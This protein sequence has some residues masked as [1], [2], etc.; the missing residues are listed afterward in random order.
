[1]KKL[2]IASVMFVIMFSA[3]LQAQVVK[4]DSVLFTNGASL[5]TSLNT[6]GYQITAIKIPDALAGTSITFQVND[7]LDATY[8]NLIKADGTEVKITVPASGTLPNR[9]L[10]VT[11]AENLAFNYL[12]KL[13]TGTYAAPTTQSAAIWVYVELTKMIG[14]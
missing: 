2:M 14:E 12:A 3:M 1:M 4:I 9:K 5:S 6:T 11:P 10:I 13:R 8:Y 7:G